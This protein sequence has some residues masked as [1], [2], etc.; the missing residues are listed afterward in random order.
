MVC[1][2]LLTVP[3]T[4]VS[5]QNDRPKN[6]FN[7][8]IVLDASGSMRNTD[9]NGYRYEAIG[10]FTGLLAQ[11]GNVLGGVVFH[12]GVEAELAPT[13]ITNQ[14]GKDAVT[15]M[16]ESV[17]SNDGWTNTGAGLSRAVEMLKANGDPNLPSVV[18]TL[19]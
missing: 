16:L 13:L 6:R 2:L 18:A 4:R 3:V 10:Q 19:I 9:P 12:D 15:D 1:A 17:P 11:S 5:A 8:A 7:V 14:A